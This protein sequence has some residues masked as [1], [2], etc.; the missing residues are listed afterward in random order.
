M[1][2]GE[3]LGSKAEYSHERMRLRRRRYG[4]M[5]GALLGIAAYGVGADVSLWIGVLLAVVF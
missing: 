4:G 1:G 5:L 3:S 2:A